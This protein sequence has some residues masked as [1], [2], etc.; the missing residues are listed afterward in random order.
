MRH[1]LNACTLQIKRETETQKYCLDTRNQLYPPSL[2]D[3]G[4]L[5]GCKNSDLVNILDITKTDAMEREFDSK[6]FDAAALVH[7]MKPTAV[8]T[9]EEYGKEA[10]LAFI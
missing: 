6:V 4:V 5:R 1:H 2:S 8:A 10:F 3:H 7:I 9:F